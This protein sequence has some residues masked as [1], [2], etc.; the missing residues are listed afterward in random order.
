MAQKDRPHQSPEAQRNAVE[1]SDHQTPYIYRKGDCQS[2]RSLPVWQTTLTTVIE[3]E[4][5]KQCDPGCN[6]LRCMG[7]NSDDNIRC[8]PI[9][10]DLHRRLLQAHL[11]IPHAVE[12][13][14]MFSH[15][16][17]FKNVVEKATSRFDGGKEYFSDAFTTYL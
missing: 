1:R 4:E 8:L 13:C 17:K 14:S 6:T 12:D 7:A 2:L 10:C 3:R 11:D 16:Q 9:Q 15:F 5:H